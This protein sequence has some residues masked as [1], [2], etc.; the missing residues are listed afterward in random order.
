[1]LREESHVKM[2]ADTEVK[3]L[4]A[5]G[6]EGLPEAGRGEGGLSLRLPR[7]CGLANTLTVHLQ[8]PGL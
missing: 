5:K 6:H 4:H 2:E 3:L 1:M 8:P 7:E